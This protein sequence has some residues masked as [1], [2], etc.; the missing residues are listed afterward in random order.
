MVLRKNSEGRVAIV[1]SSINVRRLVPGLRSF[2][3]GG[4]PFWLVDIYR[5]L[6]ELKGLLDR[7]KPEAVLTEWLPGITDTIISWGWPTVVAPGDVSLKGV[8]TVDVDDEAVGRLAA[9]H[10]VGNGLRNFAFFGTDTHYTNQRLLGFREG[11]QAV[12]MDEPEV[13]WRE[14]DQRRQYIEYWH[15]STDSLNDWL[16]GLPKPVGLFVAHDP[17]GRACAEAC[18]VLGI[19][20]PDEIAILGVNDDALVC[21]LTSPELSSVSIPWR[22]IGERAGE[23]IEH[24]LSGEPF[25][26]KPILL[27]PG[28]IRRRRSSD[29]VA[30]EDPRIRRALQVMRDE[31]YS[32]I[33]VSEIA[34]SASI[35]RRTLEHWFRNNLSMSPKEELTRMRVGRSQQLLLETDWSIERIAETVGYSSA[36]RF[37]VVFKQRVDSSPSMYRKRMRA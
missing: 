13:Q 8:G 7:W 6:D 19:R 37:A 3:T 36:E 17:L 11:L 26:E 20:I 5:P 30:V 25:P 4:R 29:F 9:E 14:M 28:G 24:F 1:V 18:D 21:E 23:M 12:G 16:R 31:V 10:F 2:A 34:R 22:Q 32:G 35:P 27:P 33:T 15:E